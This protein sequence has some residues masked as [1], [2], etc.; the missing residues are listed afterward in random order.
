MIKLTQSIPPLGFTFFIHL[1]KPNWKTTTKNHEKQKHFSRNS[2]SAVEY[3]H[4]YMGFN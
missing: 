3:I 2:D 1:K 4:M